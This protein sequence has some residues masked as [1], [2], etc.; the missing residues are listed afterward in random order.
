VT[1]YLSSDNHK[2]HN[3]QQ[4]KAHNSNGKNQELQIQT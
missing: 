3:L 4:F 2:N 1:Y